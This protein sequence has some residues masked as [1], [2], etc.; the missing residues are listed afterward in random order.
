MKKTAVRALCKRLRKARKAFTRMY[1]GGQDGAQSTAGEQLLAFL[2]QLCEAAESGLR[3]LR[4]APGLPAGESGLPRAFERLQAFVQEPYAPTLDSLASSLAGG[5]FS[6]TELTL[7]RLLFRTACVLCAA[8]S[9]DAEQAVR[10]AQALEKTEQTDFSRLF[11]HLSDAE[12]ICLTD[13][14]FR[15]SD[16]RTKAAY[17]ERLSHFAKKRGVSEEAAAQKL[18]QRAAAENTTLWRLLWEKERFVR[19]RV[20]TG[21]QWTLLWTAAAAVAGIFGIWW[22]LPLL[23]MPL[24]AGL[25]PIL[26]RLVLRRAKPKI[27]PTCR[28]RSRVGSRVR[29]LVTVSALLPE[30]GRE[31]ALSDHL[32]EVYLSAGRGALGLALLADLKAAPSAVRETDNADIA[33]AKRM[34]DALNEKYPGRFVLLVRGR[35]FSETQNAYT[36]FERKR[37]ALCALFALLAHGDASAFSVCHGA[38]SLLRGVHYV[39][40]LD[41]DASP[42]PDCLFRLLAAARHPENAPHIDEKARRVTRGYGIFVPQAEIS[43]ASAF[44]TRFSRLTAGAGGA[45]GTV[46]PVAAW[47]KNIGNFAFNLMIPV[48]AG[49][50]A[51]SIADRPGF[52]VGMV[53]GILAT[54]GATFSDPA[55][56]NTIPSG[57]LG[58]LL[59]SF[60]AGYLMRGL[61]RLCDR[62]PRSLEGIKPVLI[63]PLAG[64]G[65]VAVM[66]CAVNPFMG[67]IN[68][69]MND[70]L[71]WLSARHLDVLLGAIVAGMMAIDMG[72]P[73]NK[74]AY[75]FGSTVMLGQAA[76]MADPNVAYQIT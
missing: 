60:A 70:G 12:R 69:A 8:E 7:T 67:M 19:G 36:G 63:Y 32:E 65:I 76:S 47:F 53:G 42:A 35:T 50:I 64:L 39:F 18:M 62:L 61:E 11:A 44:C 14:G 15:A 30:G 38:Q 24:F 48:L 58:A 56:A 37:G 71:M 22:L 68:S 17:R 54:N 20:L 75:V 57:F 13:A 31:A 43:S 21:L 46:T 23:W 66:M 55:A 26:E 10:A 5:S 49:F 9:E 6:F 25:S 28:V 51:M 16:D 41:A 33:A 45:F 34:I 59:A 72:G 1:A 2:P 3:D 73:F 74:A 4:A 27:V 52:L 29:T 40:A